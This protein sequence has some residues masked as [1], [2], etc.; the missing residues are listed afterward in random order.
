MPHAYRQVVRRY[1]TKHES[2][3][4]SNNISLIFSNNNMSAESQKG[5]IR[6]YALNG[7]RRL[8]LAHMMASLSDILVPPS[9]R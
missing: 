3:I 2:S 7:D 9:S 5:T 4:L 1:E 6:L 8:T